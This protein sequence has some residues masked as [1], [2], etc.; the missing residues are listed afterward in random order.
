M[1]RDRGISGQSQISI[2]EGLCANCRNARRIESD[3][4]SVF[5]LCELSSRDLSF[6]KYPALPVVQCSGYE[7]RN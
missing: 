1:N 6:T 2:P 7:E 3:R 4:G 5:V